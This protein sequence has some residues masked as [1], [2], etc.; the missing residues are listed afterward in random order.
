MEKII[1][2]PND[3]HNQQMVDLTHPVNGSSTIHKNGYDLIAIGGGAAGLVT[4]GGAAFLGARSALIERHLMGGDCLVSGCVPSKAILHASRLAAQV[5]E[6]KEWGVTSDAQ[7]DFARVM[8]NLRKLRAKIAHADSAQA[9]KDRGVDTLFGDAKF[10]SPSSIVLDGKRIRFKRAVI[11]TGARPVIPPV[12]GL[13]ESNPLTHETVFNLTELPARLAVIG[14]GPIGSE[15]G[16]AFCRLGSKV[17][18]LEMGSQ[19]LPKDDSYAAKL[20]ADAMRKDGVELLLGWKLDRVESAQGEHTLTCSNGSESRQIVVDR[21]LVAAG[22][23]ANL[24][25][26]DLDRAGI[27]VDADGRLVLNHAQQTTNRRVYACGD[28]AGSYQFTH[29]A[30]AFGEYVTYNAL[31]PVRLNPFKRPMPWCTYT[32]P[33]VAHVGPTYAELIKMGNQVKCYPLSTA[34]VDRSIITGNDNGFA[35]VWTK[36]GSH[37]ILAATIVSDHAGDLISEFTLAM[38]SGSGLNSITKT[39]HPYPSHSELVRKTADVHRFETLTPGLKKMLHLWFRKG[40]R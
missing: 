13:R 14:G 37:K 25:G 8:E 23:K 40:L 27:A 12:P 28:V 24:E 29:S 10:E 20:V 38:T 4:S 2:P 15:L 18:L 33:E 3:L 6:A 11:A 7:V 22:R 5:E 21:I 31:F 1:I 36:K 19:L 34:E 39:I 26:L 30:Y 16:Q 17:S 32:S 9:F 35:K